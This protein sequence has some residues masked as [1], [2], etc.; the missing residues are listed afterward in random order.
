[1][2]K[3]TKNKLYKNLSKEIL[4]NIFLKP[5]ATMIA[6]VILEF[7]IYVIGFQIYWYADDPIYIFLI[8]ILN[9]LV[10]INIVIAIGFFIYFFFK[11]LSIINT[12]LLE[13]T[14]AA[15]EITSEDSNFIKLSPPLEPLENFLNKSKQSY[16]KNQEIAKESEQ[17]KN[18]LIMY[19]A[20][21]LKTPL[22][23]VIG[24]LTLIEDEKEI[25]KELKEKY[26]SIA[27]D[28]ALRLEDLINDFFDITRFNLASIELEK[29]EVNLS[30]ML[31]QITYE[32]LPILKEKNL[33]FDLNIENDVNYICDIQKM[34]RVFDNLIRNAINYS[35]ENNKINILLKQKNSEIIIKFTNNGLQYLKKS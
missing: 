18:D 2:N 1:M 17:R 33:S 29:S 24:Y 26:N 3:K 20:H 30:V 28:K 22:T 6:L 23:S 31:E 21:D 35:Y 8:W 32:F 16:K 4:F 11:S 12:Y 15:T 14:N 19:L 25:S 13:I 10:Q 5:L 27:L 7:V 34:E 9:H